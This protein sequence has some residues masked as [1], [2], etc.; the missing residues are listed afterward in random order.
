[1]AQEEKVDKEF[2]ADLVGRTSFNETLLAKD[3]Y[4]TRILF[5]L[6]DVK[7][8]YFKG[9][10]ALQKIFLDH[11]RLSEDIDFTLTANVKEK[12]EEIRKILKHEQFIKEITKDKSV[13]GFTRM[14]VHYDN[15]SEETDTIFI[16]LNA[17]GK[18]LTKPESH[19]IKHFY[20]DIHPFNFPTLSQQEMFA[21]KVAAAVSRN[22]PRDHYDIY[23]ILKKKFPINIAL[24][25]RKCRQSGDEFSIIR[26]F[27]NAKKLK[28]RWD[29]DMVPLLSKPES[30]EEIMKTLSKHFNL[31]Q[32]KAS[33]KSN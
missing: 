32:A 31:K 24:V 13:D 8:I 22:K 28:N 23:L 29:S 27:N 15:F 9:G 14:V 30:F 10:T 12:E 17:R 25:E 6:K 19:E 3:Y 1:M 4:I 16:D 33:N 5:L 18:L 7:G 21:E 11:S 2:I 20:P 26:M